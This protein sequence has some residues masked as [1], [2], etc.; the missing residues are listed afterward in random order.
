MTVDAKLTL[1]NVTVSGTVITDNATMELD[2]T[3]TLDRRRQVIQAHRA[4]RRVRSPTI[5]TLESRA[6][7]MT[8][9][10]DILT[11]TGGHTVQ[12]DG[13]GVLDA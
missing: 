11:N 1:D 5:G 3:V 9:L 4:H 2:N 12:V 10:N 6:G 8:L 13:T 7:Q